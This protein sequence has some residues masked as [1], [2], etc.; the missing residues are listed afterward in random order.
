MTQDFINTLEL[1]RKGAKV[2]SREK[3]PDT[4]RDE[5]IR[6]LSF[7]TIEKPVELVRVLWDRCRISFRKLEGVINRPQYECY[8][9]PKRRGGTREIQA[10]KGVLKKALKE[11]N[12]LLQV[13]YVNIKPDCV[14]GFVINYRQNNDAYCNIVANARPHVNKRFVLNMDIKDFFPSITAKRVYAMFESDVFGFN[15]QIATALML[16][17]TYRGK[18]PTGA[19]SSP[20][21]SNF[22]CLD[23]DRALIAFCAASGLTYTR[24]AD[25]L[26]FSSDQNIT[27][28][29]QS[30][31][32]RIVQSFGFQLNN[33]KCRLLNSRAR[34]TVTGLV[35]NRKVNIDRRLL[36][37]IRAMLHDLNTRGVY[38]ASR[39]HFRIKTSDA[40]KDIS[41][42][43]LKR[44]D[45]YINFIGQV[46]GRDGMYHKM[47]EEFLQDRG[48]TK[49]HIK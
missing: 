36:K 31:I 8:A 44:L 28:E 12:D 16:L 41:L 6:A 19:P 45:G 27:I 3:T 11:I 5:D 43:F 34:Q 37:R 38:E 40:P 35:V 18:L 33:G 4:L 46:R 49:I 26:T 10:P 48:S 29:L 1:F 9:I 42:M 20:V 21:I 22:I 39:R 32:A 2:S 23:M 47:R 30:E 17:C 24:Y 7:L 14:H 25:D 15:R 13:Y